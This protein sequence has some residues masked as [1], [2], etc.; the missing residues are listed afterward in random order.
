ML[1]AGDDIVSIHL[2]GGMSGTVHSAEQAR[3]R[4]GA[5]ADR[6]HVIDSE[7][8]CGGQGLVVLAAAAAAQSGGRRRRGGGAHPPSSGAA[9]ALVRDR[10][11]RVPAPRRPDRRS[12][13]LAWLCAED[14]AD[15]DRGVGDHPGRAGADLAPRVRADGRAAAHGKEAG[16]DAWMIQ[17]IQAPDRSGQARR[18]AASRSSAADPV[19]VAE[20]GPV[21]GTHVGPGLLG[22]GG[23]PSSF[24]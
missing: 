6:V 15:P 14:Q 7:S 1:E 10:H 4:L 22:A 5:R 12:A 18:R 9:E 24:L 23:I 11:P 13:G 3:E 16:A 8:A 2:A 20:I 17:H 19:M 21:I